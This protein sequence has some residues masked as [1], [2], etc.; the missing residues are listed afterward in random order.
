MT[1][2][3]T[4]LDAVPGRT[5]VPTGRVARLR[6]YLMCPP[7]HFEVSYAINP[8]M[9]PDTAEDVALA[10][11]QWEALRQTYL[12]LG[13]EVEIVAAELGLPDMVFAAKDT[14]RNK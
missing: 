12:A 14:P 1:V 5:T 9:N 4:V 6:R 10:G 11:R 3:N 2:L 13:H 8:W 7:D